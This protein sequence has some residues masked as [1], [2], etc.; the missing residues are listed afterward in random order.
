MKK[1]E[2]TKNDVIH[3]ETLEEFNRIMNLFDLDTEF[4]DWSFYE[5]DTVLYPLINQYG[6]I[7]G[8]CYERELNIIN[9]IDLL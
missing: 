5:K 7:T 9:S 1:S 3:C 2:I 6:N 8:D 4:M